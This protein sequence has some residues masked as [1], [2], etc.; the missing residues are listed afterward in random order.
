MTVLPRLLAVPRARAH[1]GP[2]H[3][4]VSW[5]SAEV[6]VAPTHTP[7]E[8]P[9]PGTPSHGTGPDPGTVGGDAGPAGQGIPGRK[10]ERCSRR[11]LGH[12]ASCQPSK[13]LTLTQRD[14]LS[15]SSRKCRQPTP[16][17]RSTGTG[18]TL[19]PAL[20]APP[21][22]A[23]G[24]SRPCS[25][26]RDSEAL[27]ALRC[28]APTPRWGPSPRPMTPQQPHHRPPIPSHRPAGSPGTLP[29]SWRLGKTLLSANTPTVVVAT[30]FQRCRWLQ[31]P[32][33]PRP[34]PLTG[35][36]VLV[37]RGV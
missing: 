7:A 25:R 11:T 15:V 1:A 10:T 37:S 16:S 31:G 22:A 19:I 6:C 21:P 17:A 34:A 4:V 27:P 26:C 5:G 35:S 8:S 32:S 18:Q 30:R 14:G 24:R 9:P 20:P 23:G 33:H 2:G 13:T 28:T 12:K 3:L 29:E 36:L